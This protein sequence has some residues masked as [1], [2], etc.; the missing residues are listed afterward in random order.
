[1]S[2]YLVNHKKIIRK[3]FL[4][5][6]VVINEKPNQRVWE[7]KKVRIHCVMETPFVVRTTRD[8]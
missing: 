3:H 1:V 4:I 7:R 8:R 6:G 5:D 2:D